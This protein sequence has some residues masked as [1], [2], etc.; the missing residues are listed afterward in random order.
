MTFTVSILVTMCF[1]FF[2]VCFVGSKRNVYF[3]TA[4]CVKF[5]AADIAADMILACS[6]MAARMFYCANIY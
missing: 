1:H 6:D 3:V 2:L 4:R 5:A